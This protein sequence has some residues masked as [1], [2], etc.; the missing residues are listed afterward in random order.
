MMRR[1]SQKDSAVSFSETASI[2]IV[3]FEVATLGA[4]TGLK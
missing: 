3:T 1:R 2:R 4:I